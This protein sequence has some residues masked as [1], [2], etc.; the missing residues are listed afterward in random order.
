M[1][2]YKTASKLF[3]N[4]FETGLKLFCFSFIS[5]CG[6]LKRIFWIHAYNWFI[7]WLVDWFCLQK[8]VKVSLCNSQIWIGPNLSRFPPRHSVSH[9][10]A[11]KP[12]ERD[13]SGQWGVNCGNKGR[14][15]KI[16]GDARTRI[17][18]S[19]LRLQYRR[20]H[21]APFDHGAIMA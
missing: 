17:K 20:I 12:K 15:H 6:Q 13:A 19:E 16:A 7:D 18:S 3:K 14:F 9:Y 4:S 5:L 1:R 21:N 8:T 11:P 2:P 10:C